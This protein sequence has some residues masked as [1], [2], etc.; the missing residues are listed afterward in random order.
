[1]TPADISEVLIKNRRDNDKALK[2]VLETL[3]K[4][5]AANRRKRMVAEVEEVAEEEEKRALDSPKEI[6]GAANGGDDVDVNYKKRVLG[7]GNFV[8][9]YS[10]DC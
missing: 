3:R 6:C 4:K 8:G 1:M 2:E 9:G 10:G 5:K 7:Y